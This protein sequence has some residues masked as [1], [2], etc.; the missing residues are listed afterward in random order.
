MTTKTC[1]K[2][3]ETKLL[4]DFKQKN[5]QQSSGVVKVIQATCKKCYN[6][7]YTGRLADKNGWRAKRYRSFI[8]DYLSCRLCV[9][10]GYSNWIALEFDH[11]PQYQKLSDISS[12]TQLSLDRIQAEIAKCEVVCSNCHSIRSFKRSG[13]WR[14]QMDN[15]KNASI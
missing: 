12:M 15:E 1:T 13:A 10:C 6:K 4:E 8:Y 5:R 14:I 3:N 9:D 11:L 2:C 7:L